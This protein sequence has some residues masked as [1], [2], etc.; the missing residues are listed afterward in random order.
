[1]RPTYLGFETSKSALYASQKAL[2]I[3]GN[4]LANISSEGYT[5]QRVAQVSSNYHNFASKEYIGGRVALAGQG[6]TILGIAQT[7][8]AQVDNAFRQQCAEIGE[9]S[10][11]SAMLTEI[12]DA[13]QE[14][15]IGTDGD[16]Y[17]LRNAVADLYKALQD[18]SMDSSSPTYA[19]VAADAFVRLEETINEMYGD[20]EAVGDKYKAALDTDCTNVNKCLEKIAILN[21]DIREAMVVNQYTEEYGPNE[22]LDERNMLLD[23][24]SAYGEVAVKYNYDGTVDVSLGGHLAVEGEISDALSYLENTDGTVEI[25]WKNTGEPAITGQGILNASVDILNGRG[26]EMQNSTE[27]SAKGI[28]YYKDKLNKFA[29]HLADVCNTT[30]PQEIDEYGNV[31]SYKQLFG[32]YVENSNG[33]SDVYNDMYI[34]AENI[35]ISNE[36]N[37]SVNYLLFDG[38]GNT[39]NTYLLNLIAR[40]S[41][42]DVS[43]G[44]FTGTFEEYIADYATG[45]GSDLSYANERNE[46]ATVVGNSLNNTRESIMGVSE[47]EET[48]NMLAYNRAFQA[49]AKMMNMMDSMLDVIINQMGV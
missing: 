7:R 28:L 42:S 35:S 34:T 20:L 37:E 13:L 4:N 12:E 17:G 3:T 27:T 15:D 48:T 5:R 43:F 1:M 14:Y 46:A 9:T 18:F 26:T 33:V 49:A 6:T 25:A 19:T 40:L 39:D 45:L 11:R 44:D 10:Q 2:D 31:I 47:T 38:G 30:I 24:L 16:G 41:D 32:A 29:L 8:D 22:L 23:E 36:L 21:K